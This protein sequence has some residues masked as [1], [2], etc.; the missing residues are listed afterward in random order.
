VVVNMV[1][2]RQEHAKLVG[3]CLQKGAEGFIEAGE[4]LRRAKHELPHGEYEAMVRD[5][6]R[7]DPS[8]ARRLT[9]IASNPVLSDRAHGHALPPSWRTLY[10]L[11][12]LPQT[13]LLT[14]I[15]EGAIYPAMERKQVLEIL[16]PRPIK[17]KRKR[18]KPLDLLVRNEHD[19]D[20][21]FLW[22]A[23]ESLRDRP[24]AIS[25]EGESGEGDPNFLA[26]RERPLPLGAR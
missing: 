19:R 16:P 17:R 13:L 2:T 20:F 9:A 25:E 4:A 11:T 24:R 10:E 3:G 8:T 5:D 14:K 15:E 6:L 12:K 1:R 7:M 22:G 26:G 18:A 21:E 23:W